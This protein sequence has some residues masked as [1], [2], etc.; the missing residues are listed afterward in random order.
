MPLP[1]DQLDF[2]L[3][4]RLL[5]TEPAEPRDSAKLLVVDRAADR[6]AHHRVRDLP[7]LGVLTADDLVVV[8]D[9]RVAPAYLVATRAATGGRVTGLV[10]DTDLAA[11]PLVLTLLLESRGKPQPGESL[12]IQP[13]TATPDGPPIRPSADPPTLTLRESLGHGKWLATLAAGTLDDLHALGATPLPP[14]IRKARRHHGQPELNP[15]DPARYNT[16]YASADPAAARSAAAPTAGL[17]FTPQLLDR[18]PCPL[19]RVTLHV[20]QGTFAPVRTDDL[21]DHPIHAEFIE[22]TQAACDAIVAC[23]A[24]GGN[25]L[26]VG[27]TTLRCLESL[28][29]ADATSPRPSGVGLNASPL[30]YTGPTD[31]FITPTRTALPPGHPDRF[32]FRFTDRLMTNFHLP[33]STLLALVAALPGLSVDRL[34]A[35]YQEAI[36]HEYRFYS[37]GDAMLIV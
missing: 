29:A 26:A 13:A 37:Y 9:T 20:G 10:L 11:T 17:H 24:R 32:A 28:P 7:D 21:D 18:L 5:A 1:I 4:D 22:V 3:P 12:I 16:V 8:N 34:L 36:A 6:V 35:L 31:L 27:T 19:T 14:Y 15:A 2:H 25:I 30:P 23:R 33:K